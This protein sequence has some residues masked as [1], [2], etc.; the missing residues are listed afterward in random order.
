M[1]SENRSQTFEIQARDGHPLRGLLLF[2]EQAPRAVVQINSATGA[3]RS[4][5]RPFAE[6]LRDH[7]FAVCLWDYRGSG[8]SINKPLKDY[9]DTFADYG[10]KD[11]P[12]I[13][14]FL[15][16]T[17]PGVPKIAVG[18]SVGGQL[19]GLMDNWNKLSGLV[20]LGT[21]GGQ[22]RYMPWGYW[23]LAV[24]FFYLFTPLSHVFLGYCA[25][26]KLGHMEN[27]PTTVVREWRDWCAEA[28]YLFS[29]KFLGRTIPVGHFKDYHFPVSAYWASDDPIANR[30][31]VAQFW[32]EI[33][34]TSSIRI[35]ELKPKD[36]GL[37]E[38]AH[39]GY[40]RKKFETTLWQE[41]L[42]DIESFIAT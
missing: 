34:S 6:F 22:L 10:L 5:Y 11:M 32:S 16:Q 37:R 40:F 36:F 31:S 28:E 18:H 4:Y 15:D 33:K 8:E 14:D 38:I 13:L 29:P 26:K 42:K 9:R 24:Y 27:L 39:F 3:K 1:T 25:G 21:S 30:R 2:P 41:L 35:Q 23:F 12:A 19:I 7:G 17:F 20:T